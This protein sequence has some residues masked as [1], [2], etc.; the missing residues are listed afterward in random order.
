MAAAADALEQSEK[1]EPDRPVTLVALGLALNNRKMYDEA[2]ARLRRALE[3]DP[4][5]VEALAALAE[6][7]EAQGEMGPAE[8]HAQRALAQQAGHATANRAV[9]LL[10]M[11][12][13]RQAEARDALL[14]ALA[15]DAD[16]PR[17]LYLLS[18]VYARLGEA[19]ASEAYREAYETQLRSAEQRIEAIR[20]ESGL[21]GGEGPGR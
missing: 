16:A 20:R 12:Q 18:L 14:R 4:A 13:G 6:A 7:E 2:R 15:A 10:R 21:A 19:T 8:E 5:S 9:G 3:L 17:T 11:K 1:L